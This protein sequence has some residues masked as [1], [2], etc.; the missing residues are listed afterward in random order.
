ML[1]YET[2]DRLL[3]NSLLVTSFALLSR[4]CGQT[5]DI[6]QSDTLLHVKLYYGGFF[7]HAKLSPLIG[8]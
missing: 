1:Q 5:N 2:N 8:E 4:T 6:S 3:H 7:G